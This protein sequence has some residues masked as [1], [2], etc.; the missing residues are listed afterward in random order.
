MKLSSFL[1]IKQ[2]ARAIAFELE[3]LNVINSANLH[4]VAA[5]TR[6]HGPGYQIWNITEDNKTKAR[7]AKTSASVQ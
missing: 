3:L 1:F 6:A 2:R 4:M 5:R 7:L